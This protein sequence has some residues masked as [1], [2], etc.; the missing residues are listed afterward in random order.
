MIESHPLSRHRHLLSGA[1]AAVALAALFSLTTNAAIAQERPLRIIAFGAHPD[2]CE[3]RVGGTAAKWAK[4]GHKVKFVS[5]T[6]GDIGHA[7][8]AGGPLAQRR[9]KEVQE[10]AKILGIETQV[11]DNHDGE[12]MPTLEN[13]KTVIRLIREWEADVV[14]TNRPNDYHPDHRYTSILVQD[15]AFMVMVPFICPDTPPLKKNPVFLF[16]P[17][18]FKKPIPF[19]PDIVVSIDDVLEQKYRALHCLVSQIY[20]RGALGDGNP[21]HFV[22]GT[23]EER[24]EWLKRRRRYDLPE[25]W[26]PLVD[27]YYGKE[28]ARTIKSVEAFEICEYGR[29][30]SREELKRLFP[31]FPDSPK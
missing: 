26:R 1:V 15:S 8:I 12:L 22:K 5:T 11:L 24:L 6:N 14:I 10:A 13:R 19:K 21:D 30:P 17:D 18:R 31:F 27:E 4:L 20:E 28:N 9:T 25:E 3:F 16:W 23:D 29:Q 2:D 7:I